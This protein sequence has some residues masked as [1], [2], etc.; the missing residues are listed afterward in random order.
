MKKLLVLL[1][2][3]IF[4]SLTTLSIYVLNSKNI[5]QVPSFVLK[6]KLEKEE[7]DLSKIFHDRTY[8]SI[9]ERTKDT[10]SKAVNALKAKFPSVDFS[11]L[12]IEI[13]PYNTGG[14]DVILKPKK[15]SKYKN[16]ASIPCYPKEDLSK[17]IKERKLTNIGNIDINTKEKILSALERFG[18]S[19]FVEID[20]NIKDIKESSA[21]IVSSEVG[22]FYGSVEI[23]FNAR[24][25]TLESVIYE[26]NIVIE[27][28][29]QDEIIKIL[30]KK[31][32]SLINKKLDIKIEEQKKTIT[33][34]AT[35]TTEFIGTVILMYSF[36]NVESPEQPKSNIELKKEP[37]ESKLI[38]TDISKK[39][40]PES[41]SV[42]D[43]D[44]KN[45]T[46]KPK[47]DELSNSNM[48]LNDLKTPENKSE[49]KEELKT[50]KEK[51][52]ELKKPSKTPKESKIDKD[53]NSN[54]SVIDKSKSSST[55]NSKILQ[56]P[57]K[58]SSTSNKNSKSS[59]S[60][61]G[62]IVG[63]TLGVGS[64]VGIGATGSWFY[65]KKRK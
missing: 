14:I 1:S 39:S 21:T 11:Q 60:K 3:S 53:F 36:S 58:K 2:S 34:T 62:V 52:T 7:T 51:L 33:I 37:R 16:E 41:G 13:K 40:I 56:I 31:Y 5:N 65:F 8:I 49:Y 25:K 10:K 20:F 46:N 45:S 35:N 50:S 30:N 59:G 57:N 29:N 28:L 23:T 27:K 55:T 64:I 18:I 9:Q 24:K 54:T 42:N 48:S 19:D 44:N 47:T 12:E 26:K 22:D 43:S 15:T 32:K 4:F 17:K 38:E 6:Q 61:T 63:S